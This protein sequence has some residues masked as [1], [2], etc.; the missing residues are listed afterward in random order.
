MGKSPNSRVWVILAAWAAIGWSHARAQEVDLG[1][2]SLKRI[3]DL[4]VTSVSKRTQ[5]LQ[6]VATSIYVIDAEDIRR[7]GAT[8]I[9]DV[10]K[11]A[12]GFWLSD[13]S[14]TISAK[15]VREGSTAFS[16]SVLWLLDGIPITNAIIGGIF[17]NTMDLPLEDIERIEVIK[18]P[19]GTI[20][21]AN[22]ASGIISIFT[23]GGEASEGFK[24]SLSGGTQGYVAPYIRYGVEAKNDLFL[25]FWG[26]F[27]NHNGYDRNPLFAGDSLV[28]PLNGGGEIKVRN[29][30]QGSDDNQLA[31]SGGVKWDYQPS[32]TWKWSGQVMQNHANDGQYGIQLFPYPATAPSD[33]AAPAKQADSIYAKQETMDQTIVQGRLDISQGP[34]RNLF[35]NAYHWHYRYDVAIASGAIMGYDITELETQENARVLDHHRLSIGANLR[36]VQYSFRGLKDEGTVFFR[37][38]NYVAFL[39]GGFVQDEINICDRWRLTCGAKTETWSPQGLAPEILPSLRLAFKP[40]A[41]MTWWMAASRSITTPGYAQR[42][43]EV[44]VAEL[45]PAW[46]P[47][48]WI[49]TP[50]AGAGKFVALVAGGKVRP[51]DFYNL[52]FGHRGSYNRKVQWD[53]STFYSWVRNQIGLTPIDPSYQTVVASKAH[54]PDSL[55]PIYNA[56]LANYESY[57]GESFLRYFPVDYLRLELSYAM[58]FIRNFEGLPIPDD[59]E[60][61]IYQMPEDYQSRTPNHVGRVRILA[62]L[63]WESEITIMGLVAS[64]FSRGEAFNYATQ[65]PAS[66]SLNPAQ[67]IVADPPGMEYQ[68]DISVQK[69]L[70][71][72][73]LSVSIWGRNLLADP[74]V[75]IYNQYAW[76]SFPH[77]V[78]RTFG[79]GLIYQY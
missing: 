26:R 56:N 71:K 6:D 25:T 47:G 57:G 78:H 53:V 72:N 49:G 67:A 19:G 54:A 40:S 30:F 76:V 3:M 8:R 38:P 42:D 46:L 39:A 69:Q 9:Q 55:V 60:G 75:E 13:A 52:E 63:P 5:K 50:P 7:S 11:L 31:A 37:D 74:F 70:L 33:P 12:P 1:D 58:F 79:G 2:L 21:G 65:V 77:Q 51:V 45:P 23:K 73:R 15:G 59:R 64:P 34:D 29:R 48:A 4:D 44:R 41:N 22:A 10:L 36:R 43:M 68:L 18:G 14:Y 27:K 20:Y 32:E 24:A 62:D 35:A 28:A 61:R 17:F 16:N 66:E